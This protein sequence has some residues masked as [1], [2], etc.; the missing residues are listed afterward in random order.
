MVEATQDV[1]QYWTERRDERREQLLMALTNQHA[2]LRAEERAGWT[3]TKAGDLVLVRDFVKEKHHG[4]VI[5]LLAG[6]TQQDGSIIV[7]LIVPPELN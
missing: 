2:C 7:S 5:D 1:L 4:R 6:L 3:P